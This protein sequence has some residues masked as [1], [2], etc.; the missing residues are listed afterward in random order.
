M[1]IQIESDVPLSS[2]SSVERAVTPRYRYIDEAGEHLHTLDGIPLHGTSTIAGA[3]PKEGLTW[4][5]SEVASVVCLESGQHIPTIRE[6]YAAVVALCGKDK[7]NARDRLQRKYPIFKKARYA[8]RD[9]RDAKAVTGTGMHGELE[10]YIKMCIYDHA[11]EPVPVLDGFMGREVG[12]FAE[13]ALEEVDEFLWA[14][15]HCYSE[16][17]WTGGICDCGAILRRGRGVAIIDHKSSQDAFPAQFAQLGGYDTAISENGVLTPN[18]ARVLA[19]VNAS[20]LI[21][22]PFGAAE[23]KPQIRLDV[24]NCRNGF[25]SAAGVRKFLTAFEQ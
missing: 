4:W 12:I 19:P 2:L 25:R 1:S 24:D 8:H 15:G 17:L 22:F 6:E 10:R 5:A 20:A 9:H 14:E 18:G 13:W 21:V 7:K 3:M 23:P 16:A 11:G